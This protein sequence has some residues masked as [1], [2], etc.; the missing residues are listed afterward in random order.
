MRYLKEQKTFCLKNQKKSIFGKDYYVPG[1]L[2][3]LYHKYA[4]PEFNNFFQEK[5]EVN[6]LLTENTLQNN[7][8]LKFCITGGRYCNIK[9]CRECKNKLLAPCKTSTNT[10]N[11]FTLKFF[12]EFLKQFANKNSEDFKNKV[13]NNSHLHSFTKKF[14]IVER[15]KYLLNKLKKTSYCSALHNVTFNAIVQELLFSSLQEIEDKKNNHFVC[16][17]LADNTA[18]EKM[19]EAKKILLENIG[20]ALTIKELSKKVAINE[21]YLKKGFKEVFG[22]TIFDFYL[23]QKMEH[24]KFLLYE[25]K[26]TVTDVSAILGYS[27]ISHFSSAFKKQTGLKPCEL[28]R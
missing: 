26:L 10:Y 4:V 8:Q 6:Y 18:K 20:N 5:G 25:Q 16:K 1:A 17:F 7:L 23:Q 12:P 27:S 19:Y 21:C 13:F 15:Q 3:L 28:L 14:D 9:N 11:E 2:H 24:A 22:I